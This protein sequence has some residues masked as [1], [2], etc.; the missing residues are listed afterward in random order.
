MGR[1][2]KMMN[3]SG[4]S[5]SGNTYP[6]S[7]AISRNLLRFPGKYDVIHLGEI[8]E[9]ID[10]TPL[11]KHEGAPRMRQTKV[12]LIITTPN[13]RGLY[14]CRMTLRWKGSIEIAPIPNPLHG[15]GHIHLWAPDVLNQTA[16]FCGGSHLT[17]VTIMTFSSDSSNALKDKPQGSPDPRPFLRTRSTFLP[18]VHDSTVSS[19]FQPQN[20]AVWFKTSGAQRWM[21]PYPC[22]GFGIGAIS[23]EPFQRNVMR[24]L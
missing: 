17:Q 2:L 14:N 11:P 13:K 18:H 15:Y 20:S 24:Q 9:H 21:C 1:F 5:R 10:P 12:C 7:L 8:I 4:K 6:S 23:I 19:D 22:K 16:E 3:I